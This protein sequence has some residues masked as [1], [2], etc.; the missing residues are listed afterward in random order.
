M[1][2]QIFYK[3]PFKSLRSGTVYTVNIYKDATLPSGYPLTLKG[4]AEP[5]TT[6]EDSD[7]DM[8]TPI[9]T[10][11][12]YIRIVDDGYAVNTSNVSVAFDWKT[13][14]PVNDTDRPVTLTHQ[15]GGQTIVDWQGFMQ[16]QNFGSEL[17]GNPQEHEFPVQCCLS[18]LSAIKVS[19]TI[20]ELKNFAF[21]I[22][23]MISQIP[24]C[25]ITTVVVQGGSDARTWL[26]KKF[27]W[28]NFL[29]NDDDEAE[30]QYNL[31]EVLEDFTTFW[32]WTARTM[33]QT[34]YLTCADDTTEQSFLTLTRQQLS[35]LSVGTSAGTV[36][37]G[38]PSTTFTGDIFASRNNDDFMNRGPQRAVVTVNANREDTVFKCFPKSVEEHL[39]GLGYG[40]WVQGE[41]DMTGYFSTPIERSFDSKS[42]TGTATSQ[43]GFC[44]RQIYSSTDA[45]EP[46]ICDMIVVTAYPTSSPYVQ[47]RTKKAMTLS[48]GSL[49]LKATI[50]K[51]EKQWTSEFGMSMILQIGV[52]PT[53]NRSDAKWWNIYTDFITIDNQPIIH[54]WTTTPH[55]IM[56]AFQGSQMQ[57]SSIYTFG[58]GY[59]YCL[60]FPK[61]P[62]EDGL[63]GFIF[64]DIFGIE[65]NAHPSGD[66]PRH[67]EPY[68]IA[69]LE[70]TFTRDKTV[71][72]SRIDQIRPRELIA[73]RSETKEYKASN[74]NQTQG[75][76][77][78][79]CIF[80]SDN[81]LAYGYGLLL[82]PD[83]TY[84]ETVPYGATVNHPEQH[85]ADRVAGYWAQAKRRIGT[86]IRSNAV[87]SFDPT[88]KIVMDSTTFAPISIS[89]NWRDDIIKLVLLE[90]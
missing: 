37:S 7:E 10:Q 72:P 87:P 22:D 46:T 8:F 74:N 4:A 27:D 53:T 57:T 5:F 67:A 30:S 82:N 86:E 44:R 29:N 19:T 62:I 85:L 55:T 78:A 63:N 40:S 13:M 33:G 64:I 50:Y 52:S 9:R 25:Q 15:E 34:L 77:N 66:D 20:N 16:A 14:L 56:A 81:N 83:G 59:A 28:Q 48:G 90:I 80:A 89:H 36:T 60:N 17:Y 68:E 69:D 71:L 12:G 26:L 49:G 58:I 24:C 43:A 54:E 45:T 47:L 42:I 76:W 31:G 23:H 51:G 79:D 1:A 2:F 88:H 70:I 3:I 18:I 32:G 35:T 84:M 61:I 73:S 6:D 11:S 65:D 75:E 39:E 38:I 41:K 21:L